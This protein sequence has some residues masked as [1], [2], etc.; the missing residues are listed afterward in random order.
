MTTCECREFKVT[1]MHRVWIRPGG[2]PRARRMRLPV[3]MEQRWRCVQCGERP[4]E[5]MRASINERYRRA[6]RD[7]TI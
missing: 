6:K 5:E 2:F 3:R 7:G 4:T 1:E